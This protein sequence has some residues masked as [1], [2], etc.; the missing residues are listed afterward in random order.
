MSESTVTTS[1]EI[2]RKPIITDEKRSATRLIRLRP[3]TYEA[4]LKIAHMKCDNFNNITNNLL[5]EYV[6]ENQKALEDF[7]KIFGKN[8]PPPSRFKL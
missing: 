4:M 5:E 6:K 1:T 7:E 3:S 8:P 2:K